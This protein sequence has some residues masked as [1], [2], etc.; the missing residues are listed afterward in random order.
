MLYKPM[1][2]TPTAKSGVTPTAKSG[3][4]TVL[5]VEDDEELRDLIGDLLEEEGYEVIAAADGK[6]AMDYLRAASKP[7]SLLLLDL[8]MP[9]VNGWELLRIMKG[10]QWL[11]PIP[12]VVMTAVKRDRPPGAAAVLKKPFKITELLGTVFNLVGTGG[13]ERIPGS[14]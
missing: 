12:V 1:L 13:V 8:M 2:P 14:V 5:V 7:P 10:D 9:V 11:A 3:V 6:E 4:R